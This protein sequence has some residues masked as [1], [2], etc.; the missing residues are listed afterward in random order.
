MKML[1]IKECVECPQ[2][3]FTYNTLDE[4]RNCGMCSDFHGFED[5]PAGRVVKCS[6]GEKEGKDVGM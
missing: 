2:P 3:S 6:F 4:V 5:T 1:F